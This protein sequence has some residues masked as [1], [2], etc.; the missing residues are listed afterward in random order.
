MLATFETYASMATWCYHRVRGLRE[1]NHALLLLL[2]V[3]FLFFA[4]LFRHFLYFLAY[5][6][7][8]VIFAIENFINSFALCRWGHLPISLKE[9]HRRLTVLVENFIISCVHPSLGCFSDVL[10]FLRVNFK[11]LLQSFL[12][13]T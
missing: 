11:Y 1:A 3:T 2:I 5:W 6:A 7:F 9:C 13:L 12:I 4:L 10:T 8:L